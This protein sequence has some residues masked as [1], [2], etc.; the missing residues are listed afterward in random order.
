MKQRFNAQAAC[1]DS[2]YPNK[3]PRLSAHSIRAYQREWYDR[4]D[5]LHHV[6]GPYCQDP[7]F[8]KKKNTKSEIRHRWVSNC[9]RSEQNIA[10]SNRS[11]TLFN[12]KNRGRASYLIRHCQYEES[13]EN[14]VFVSAAFATRGHCC[15]CVKFQATGFSSNTS[16]H[17]SVQ[18][19]R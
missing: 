17:F 4:R 3:K 15:F 16:Q 11:P 19:E 10:S 5:T 14:N 8:A 6:W 18:G 7:S 9:R 13:E 2:G 12:T 1:F